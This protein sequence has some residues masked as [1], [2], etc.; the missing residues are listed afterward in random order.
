MSTSGQYRKKPSVSEKVKTCFATRAERRGKGR[1]AE[2]EIR[3]ALSRRYRKGRIPEHT[4][5][6]LQI[7]CQVQAQCYLFM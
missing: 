5:T 2:E 3:G 1:R 7:Q 6:T 4:T